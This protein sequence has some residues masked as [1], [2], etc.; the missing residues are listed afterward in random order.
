MKNICLKRKSD[1]HYFQINREVAEHLMADKPGEFAFTT[2][3][4]CKAYYKRMAKTVANERVIKNLDF[5]TKQNSTFV[6]EDN[7]KVY[8]YVLRGTTRINTGTPETEEEVQAK[9][10]WLEKLIETA[11]I[12]PNDQTLKTNLIAK[13]AVFFGLFKDLFSKK[14]KQAPLP[15]FVDLPKY[16]RYIIGY[17]T[18]ENMKIA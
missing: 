15:D 13:I 16:Q 9:R 3:N 14:D 18:I 17:G 8:G 1:S 10:N 4:A 2:K 7:G 6:L 5:S 12:N 11:C